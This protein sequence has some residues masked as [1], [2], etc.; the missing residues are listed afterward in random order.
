MTS[1][2]HLAIIAV[3][4]PCILQ[5]SGENMKH[6]VIFSKILSPSPKCTCAHNFREHVRKVP[7]PNMTPPPPPVVILY[8]AVGRDYVSNWLSSRILTCNV[9]VLHGRPVQ[10]HLQDRHHLVPL[11]RAELWPQVRN[12]DLRRVLYQSLQDG[13][14]GGHLRVPGFVYVCI[15]QLLYVTS[16]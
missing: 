16:G 6:P 12:L 14:R 2:Q 15:C 5:T 4:N 8:S 3:H 7:K 1:F 13:H 10:V 9:D 11:R